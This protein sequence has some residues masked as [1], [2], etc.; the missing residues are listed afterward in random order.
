[1]ETS[2]GRGRFTQDQIIG[3]LREHEAVVKT[4]GRSSKYFWHNRTLTSFKVCNSSAVSIPS[5]MHSTPKA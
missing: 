5:A 1:M 4:A 2:D 3:V